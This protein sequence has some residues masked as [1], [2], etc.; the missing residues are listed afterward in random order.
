MRIAQSMLNAD[1]GTMCGVGANAKDNKCKQ[2]Q[3][4]TPAHLTSQ[5]IPFS[6]SQIKLS[7]VWHKTLIALLKQ[8]RLSQIPKWAKT[9]DWEDSFDS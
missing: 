5:Y 3:S 9:W 2:H 1:M 7:Q 6:A 4:N 8:V